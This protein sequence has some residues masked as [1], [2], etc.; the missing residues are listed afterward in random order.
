MPGV[1]APAPSRREIGIA[2]WVDA[3]V[4]EIDAIDGLVVLVGHSGG[5]NVV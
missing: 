3:V 1:G 4:A 2:D 5:G